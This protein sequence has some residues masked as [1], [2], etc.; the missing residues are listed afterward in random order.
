MRQAGMRVPFLRM[1][2]GFVVFSAFFSTGA[3]IV[4][5]LPCPIPDELEIKQLFERFSSL[6]QFTNFFFS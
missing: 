6:R 2:S 5:I 3:S 1:P 4:D